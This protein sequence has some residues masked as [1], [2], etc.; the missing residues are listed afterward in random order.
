MEKLRVSD[1]TQIAYYV[2]DFMEPWIKAEDK[3]TLL[4]YHGSCEAAEVFTSMVPLLARHYRVVRIDER[5]LGQSRMAP[6]TYT[7][8]TEVFVADLLAVVDHLGVDKFHLLAQSSGG[9]VCVPFALAYPQRLK[10]LVLCQTPYRMPPELIPLYSLD[11]ESMSAAIL[12]YGFREWQRKVPGYRVFNLEK[13]DQVVVDWYADFRSRNPDEVNAA[14]TEWAFGVNLADKIKDIS[15][16][17]TL[18]CGEGSYQTSPEAIRF[19]KE[20]NPAIQIRTLSGNLGQCIHV[21]MPDEIAESVLN[22]LKD[23]K[24]SVSD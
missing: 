3:E 9:L 13:V 14:R 18:I 23:Q 19:V 15:V 10:S 21:V 12:K 17:T 16:P 20:Q 8:S 6:G 2:D 4:L 7:P 22:Y 5:G 11:T 1:G 24:K